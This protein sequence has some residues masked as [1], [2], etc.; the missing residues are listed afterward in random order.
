MADKIKPST[1]ARAT[2][3]PVETRSNIPSA[4]LESVAL[5]EELRA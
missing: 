5:V 4:E 2:T 3:H 1:P